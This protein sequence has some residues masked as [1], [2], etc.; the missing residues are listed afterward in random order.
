MKVT[1]NSKAL[2]GVHTETGL[3]YISPGQSRDIALSPE[4]EALARRL[5]FLTF[6]EAEA[7]E[8]APKASEALR[9]ADKEKLIAELAE[10]GVKAD[11][12]WSIDKL[13]EALEAA[14]KP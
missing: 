6:G 13:N 7:P 3:V 8:V 14:T 12:R 2:Q 1:N 5:P 4:G 9:V 10:L 11:K